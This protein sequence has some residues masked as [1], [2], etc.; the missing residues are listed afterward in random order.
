MKKYYFYYDDKEV[1][2]KD[3]KKLVAN[4]K[5]PKYRPFLRVLAATYNMFKSMLKLRDLKLIKFSRDD[6]MEIKHINFVDS[7]REDIPII[8]KYI[9]K[10]ELK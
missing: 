6:R 9:R 1:G 2:V 5:K 4:L 7:L 8:N 10:T 3:Y